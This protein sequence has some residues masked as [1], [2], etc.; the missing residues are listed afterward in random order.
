MASISK[1]S[2]TANEYISIDSTA[3]TGESLSDDQILESNDDTPVPRVVNFKMA[4][5]SLGDVINYF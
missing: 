1:P 5:A 4:Q 3:E 2:T